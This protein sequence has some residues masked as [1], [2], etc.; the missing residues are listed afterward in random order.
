MDVYSPT[1][2]LGLQSGFVLAVLL[3]AVLL[4]ERLGGTE[5]LVKRGYQLALGLTVTF[6]V[7]SSTTAFVRAPEIPK[8]AGGDISFEEGSQAEEEQELT[9]F[10]E[11][12]QNAS[13]VATIHL[14][15]GIAL[16]M[17][18]LAGLRR[19]RV[20]PIGLVLAGLLLLIFGGG[21]TR[22]VSAIDLY[23]V[24]TLVGAGMVHDTVRFV[25]LFIGAAVL[26]GAGY[27]RWEAEPPPGLAG[28]APQ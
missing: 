23:D 3:A 7:V 2:I 11:S 4:T 9:F 17:A 12:T 21:G 14:G 27:L 19:W 8:E 26:I 13:E 10:R 25:V 15:L 6:L 1:G 16:G 20:V 5:E 28:A 18:G 22:S 24:S